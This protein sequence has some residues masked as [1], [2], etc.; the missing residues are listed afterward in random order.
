LIASFYSFFCRFIGRSVYSVENFPTGNKI[1][2]KE[3]L[4]V[5]KMLYFLLN[6]VKNCLVLCHFL[7]NCIQTW[8]KHISKKNCLM[9]QVHNWIFVSVELLFIFLKDTTY[10]LFFVKDL[11]TWNLD[12]ECNFWCKLNT[13]RNWLLLILVI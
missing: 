12:Q 1:R 8:R 3:R 5:F 6:F 7:L 9:F 13:D 11:H 4:H 2:P 10:F